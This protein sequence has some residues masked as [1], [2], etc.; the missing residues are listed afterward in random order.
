M[1]TAALSCLADL[2]VSKKKPTTYHSALTSYYHFTTHSVVSIYIGFYL[3]ILILIFHNIVFNI[4]A[5]RWTQLKK[6][7]K[8]P[9][10]LTPYSACSAS[11]FSRNS[12]FLSQQ[13]SQNSV[14]QP[15]SSKILPVLNLVKHYSFSEGHVYVRGCL[16]IKKNW[17]SKYMNLKQIIDSL[18]TLNQKFVKNWISKFMHL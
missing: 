13:F 16:K 5:S 1:E 9:V 6:L 18:K 15:V 8:G 11:F 10:R 7:S 12:V 2:V 14:F 17:I 3:F 4:L